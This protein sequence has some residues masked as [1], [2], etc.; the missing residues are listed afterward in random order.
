MSLPAEVC[1][2]PDVCAHPDV[3]PITGYQK[4]CR[5]LNCT[6]AKRED[7][8]ARRYQ[9]TPPS[10]YLRQ[11]SYPAFPSHLFDQAACRGHDPALFFPSDDSG[12]VGD[13]EAKQ[14]CAGCPVQDG[15][16]EWARAQSSLHGVWGMENETERRRVRRKAKGW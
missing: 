1:T 15:C 11:P 16:R 10:G 3:A 14:V 13:R 5:C 12:A 9:Q 4:G 8:A 7:Q 2:S 6:E